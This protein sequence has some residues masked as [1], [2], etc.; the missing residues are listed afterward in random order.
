MHLRLSDQDVA[1][2]DI[3]RTFTLHEEMLKAK[4]QMS[5]LTRYRELGTVGSH[6]EDPTLGMPLEGTSNWREQNHL[7]TTYVM[8]PR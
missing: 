4:H 1:L 7:T 8:G 2:N 3:M 6:G 5:V